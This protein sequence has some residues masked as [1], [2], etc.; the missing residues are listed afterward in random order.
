MKP[1]LTLLLAGALWAQ[2]TPPTVRATADAVVSAK[3][4]SARV[5]IGVVTSAATAREASARNAQQLE[6]VLASLR[7]ALG[8]STEIKT[9]SYYLN[10]NH[11]FDKDTGQ[12][13]VTG[14]TAGNTI[15]VTTD[16]LSAAGKIIDTATQSGA[17][18]VQSLEFLLK[19]DRA[20]RAQALREAATQARSN[21]EAMAS[22]LGL[23]VVRVLSVEQSGEHTPIR[24]LANVN[25]FAG[26]AAT[27]VAPGKIEVRVAVSVTLG[28]E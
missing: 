25:M 16:D 19:D 17:N 3:P 1:V 15:Q 20:V 26:E 22:A 2:S 10:P 18:S 7:R 11:R 27:P 14:Y 9:A 28:V 6:A 4:D 21:A 13:T 12:A 23:K 24:P 8:P 5:N